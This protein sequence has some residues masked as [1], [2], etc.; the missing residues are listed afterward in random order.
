MPLW[1][2]PLYEDIVKLFASAQARTVVREGGREGDV[3]M[4]AQL[5]GGKRWGRW[6]QT[7]EARSIENDRA[8]SD[9]AGDER[10]KRGEHMFLCF[11][12]PFFSCFFSFVLKYQKSIS[13][14]GSVIT[15]RSFA[16]FFVVVFFK[17]V[18]LSFLTCMR[19]EGEPPPA[20]CSTL[21]LCRHH[22]SS[23]K[24]R[25]SWMTNEREK[26]AEITTSILRWQL[27]E[28]LQRRLRVCVC[29]WGGVFLQTTA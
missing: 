24:S 27:I 20:S 19:R 1:A 9:Y 10:E 3:Q 22:T 11:P 16:L 12:F 25:L 18:H 5:N 13:T 6:R 26:R 7:K 15:G 29:V 21:R 28:K 17:F 2:L 4:T 8:L 14:E 23:D